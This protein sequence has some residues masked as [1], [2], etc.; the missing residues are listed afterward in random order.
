MFEV[1]GHGDPESSGEFFFRFS[2]HE[3]NYF[4]DWH[5]ENVV[6]FFIWGEGPSWFGYAN[7][8]PEKV[9]FVWVFFPGG[10]PLFLARVE[11]CLVLLPL[12]CEHLQDRFPL[13]LGD[14]QRSGPISHLGC[15]LECKD[16]RFR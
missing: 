7:V 2:F 6:D 10:I 8:K 11:L 14:H 5:G 12:P 15:V 3:V 16:R 13:F 4:F 1:C 9:L